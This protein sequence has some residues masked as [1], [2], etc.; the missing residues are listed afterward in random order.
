MMYTYVKKKK[1]SIINIISIINLDSN[2]IFEW[3][4]KE[5]DIQD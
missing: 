2:A 3:N 4:N 1:I 5:I